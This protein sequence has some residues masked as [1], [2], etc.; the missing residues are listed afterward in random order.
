M[1]EASKQHI[2]TLQAT[3]DKLQHAEYWIAVLSNKDGDQVSFY[4]NKVANTGNS[5]LV[6]SHP[7]NDHDT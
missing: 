6:K 1:M 2:P 7:T 4:I 3:V 5:M